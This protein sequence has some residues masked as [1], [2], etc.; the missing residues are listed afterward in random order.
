MIR[1]NLAMEHYRLHV[2]EQWPEGPRK[3]ATL[4]AI[5]D[6]LAALSTAAPEEAA[7]FECFD[8]SSRTC[9]KYVRVL[10]A[11]A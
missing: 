7:A 3:Q 1:D 2:T 5:H 11:A 9:E 8:C 10:L 6:A 4:A